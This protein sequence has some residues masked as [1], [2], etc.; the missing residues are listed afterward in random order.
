MSAPE[1]FYTV[2][3]RQLSPD[4]REAGVSYADTER[5]D[6]SAKELRA[7]LRSAACLAPRVAY[8]LAP[9]IRITTGAGRFVVQLKDGRLHFI[10][11]SSA[12][13][14]G[15]NPTADQIFSIITGQDVE[16]DTSAAAPSTGSSDLPKASSTWRWAVG[17][18]AV[19]VILVVNFY[20]VWNYRKPPGDLLPPFR[21]LDPEP[22][23]RLLESVAGNFETG[24]TPGDRR[25]EIN[26]EG[27]IVWIK[28]GPNRTAVERRELTAQGAESSGRSA[29]LTNKKGLITVKEDFASLTL[30]GDMYLRVTR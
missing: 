5:K 7:L 20:S 26:R 16:D 17:S 21:M 3:L 23:K 22:A 25:L 30:F 6:V 19:V 14:R 1:T 24:D 9:E 8:P 10:S 18:V 12:K 11:W 27:K 29:L 28:F 2:S 13:S 4:A 15:G